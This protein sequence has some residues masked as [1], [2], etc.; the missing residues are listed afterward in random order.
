MPDSIRERL[1]AYRTGV[2]TR[3]QQLGVKVADVRRE[4]RGAR[5]VSHML[6]QL[7]N[8]AAPV[9]G[10]E[11]LVIDNPVGGSF[12]GINLEF[13]LSQSCASP[14]NLAVGVVTQST[15]TVNFPTRTDHPAPA[16]GSFW[17]DGDQIIRIGQGDITDA[18]DR[19]FAVY[20]RRELGVE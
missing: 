10:R 14:A 1:R 4:K 20:L 16:S 2:Y 9:P 18:A 8:D 17:F 3:A 11:R 7:I 19:V 13:T 15:G 12:D 6:T 5:T